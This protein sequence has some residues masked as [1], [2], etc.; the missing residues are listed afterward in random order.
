MARPKKLYDLLLFVE[1]VCKAN[2]H[3]KWRHSRDWYGENVMPN[4]SLPTSAKNDKCINGT[5]DG[6]SFKTLKN[7]AECFRAGE[8]LNNCL[9]TWQSYYPSVVGVSRAAETVAAIEIVDNTITQAYSYENDDIDSVRG[10]PEAIGKWAHLNG[11]RWSA[12]G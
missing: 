2:E 10:L 12:A 4:Y 11:I 7:T 3:A 8:D 9:R 6:F 1:F 5:F